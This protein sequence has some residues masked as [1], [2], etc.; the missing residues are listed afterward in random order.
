MSAPAVL[1][2]LYPPAVRQRWGR[3][4]R[5]E[6]TERGI[7]AWPDTVAGAVR[8]W[9]RPSDWPETT[10]GLTRRVLATALFSVTAAVTLVLRAAQPP[11]PMNAWLRP[12]MTGMW[13]LPVLAGALLAAPLPPL[14]WPAARAVCAATT[15]VMAAPAAAIA[16]ML[17]LANSGTVDRPPVLLHAVLI[18]YYWATLAFTALRACVLVSRVMRIGTVP[19]T[20][21]LRSALLLTGTGTAVAAAQNLAAVGRTTSGAGLLAA[22][23]ALGGLAVMTLRT[24]QDLRGSGG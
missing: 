17:L 20:R 4:L 13:L 2:A 21:R 16:V 14:R 22:T 3:E 7:R 10:A 23:A 6:I 18:V 9:L 5:R 24:G 15:R 8:L 1:T 19:A 12:L 11:A